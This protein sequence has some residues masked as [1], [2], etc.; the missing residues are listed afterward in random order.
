MLKGPPDLL[1]LEGASPEKPSSLL[2]IHSEINQ[3]LPILGI[4][5]LALDP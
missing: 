5:S 3:P 1:N 4:V 2:H